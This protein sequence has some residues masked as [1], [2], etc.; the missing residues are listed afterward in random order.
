MG[1]FMPPFFVAHRLV[2]WQNLT[3]FVVRGTLCVAKWNTK[4]EVK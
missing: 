2:P 1:G 3:N 4:G